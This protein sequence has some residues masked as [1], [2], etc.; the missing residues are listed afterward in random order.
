MKNAIPFFLIFVFFTFF[1]EVSHSQVQ[2][3]VDFER[4]KTQIGIPYSREMADADFP[5]IPHFFSAN[6][7]TVAK[8]PVDPNNTVIRTKVAPEKPGDSPP[9]P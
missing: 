9:A 6:V 4:W 8:D 5:D 7:T 2:I 1:A 3:D